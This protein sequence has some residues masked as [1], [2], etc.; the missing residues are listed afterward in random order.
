MSDQWYTSEEMKNGFNNFETTI[1]AAIAGKIDY[2][3]YHFVIDE[4][5]MLVFLRKD[6]ESRDEDYKDERWPCNS[7]DGVELWS[8]ETG[9][10]R[11]TE[12]VSMFLQALKIKHLS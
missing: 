4:D 6:E 2:D 8:V 9:H 1:Q 12:V 11:G 5:G 7:S 3:K 10:S